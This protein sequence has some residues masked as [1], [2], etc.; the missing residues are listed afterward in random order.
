MIERSAFFERAVASNRL[1]DVDREEG[2]RRG[3][4]GEGK[5]RGGKRKRGSGDGTT[6]ADNRRGGSGT[7]CGRGKEGRE[8]ASVS[9]VA[10]TGAGGTAGGGKSPSL[11]TSVHPLAIASA[12]LRA[13]GVDE[14]SKSINLGGLVIGGEYFGLPNVIVVDDWT[15]SS[16]AAGG[17]ANGKKGGSLLSPLSSSE[18]GNGGG[19]NEKGKTRGADAEPPA[20]APSSSSNVDPA[21][22]SSSSS[23]SASNG[24]MTDETTTLDRR[25]RSAYV[26]WRRRSQYDLASSALVRHAHRLSYSITAS[27]VLDAWLRKLR[28]RWKLAAPEHG[29][30]SSAGLAQPGEVAAVDVE[31]YRR[32]GGGGGGGGHASLG[33]IARRVPRSATLELANEYNISEDVTLLRMKIR[34]VVDGTKKAEGDADNAAMPDGNIMEADGNGKDGRPRAASP[35]SSPPPSSRAGGAGGSCKTKA[36]QFAAADPL[37]S[38]VDPNKVPLLTLL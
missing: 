31:V 8:G 2:G 1:I 4:G 12:R 21:H 24:I 32:L 38:K 10:G 34:D 19:G 23:S 28:G 33:R 36:K 20:A 3:A 14:L 18:N 22:L 11:L 26:L 15:A 5:K 37:L 27:R 35:P 29:T 7:G 30:R 9:V 6:T 16:A 13:V 17:G 25:H